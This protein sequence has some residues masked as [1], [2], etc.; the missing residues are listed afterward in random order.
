MRGVT[1]EPNRRSD[2]PLSFPEAIEKK[3]ASPSDKKD[4]KSEAINISGK[5]VEEIGFEKIQHQLA[6]LP[7]LRIVILDGLCVKGVEKTPWS[8]GTTRSRDEQRNWLQRLKIQELDLSRNLLESW[9][10]VIFINNSLPQLRALRLAGNRFRDLSIPLERSKPKEF[11]QLRELGLDD[12]LLDWEAIVSL[13]ADFPALNTLTASYNRIRTISRP[14]QNTEL[15]RLDL[16]FTE[17]SSI[18][19]IWPLSTLPN[20]KT[21]SLRSDPITTLKSGRVKLV[22]LR[23]LD[24]TSTLLPTLA[25]LSPIPVLF[26]TL[27]SLLTKDAPLSKHPSASLFTIAR[28]ANLTELNYSP[29][30]PAVRQNAELYYLSTIT[31]ELSDATSPAEEK[32][33]LA[34]H[35]RWAE[36]CR[37]YGEPEIARKKQQEDAFEAGTLGARVAKFIFSLSKPNLFPSDKFARPPSNE[38]ASVQTGLSI[39]KRDGD[40]EGEENVDLTNASSNAGESMA[41]RTRLLPLTISTYRLIGI[42][43]SLFSLR[44][45]SMQLILETDE[46]DPVTEEDGGWSVSEDDSSEDEVMDKRKSGETRREKGRWVRR[47]EELVGSTRSVGDWLPMGFGGKGAEVRVR[48]EI[49]KG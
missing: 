5:T 41:T 30:T 17:I 15:I 49:Q 29:I 18:D 32:Q 28:I 48:V 1:M 14:L 37:I 40:S 45:I 39:H 21:L 23:H 11:E 47:E 22:S 27:T 24:L 2:P 10:D 31:K 33:I 26:P 13:T 3:Y 8:A 34:F 42:A 19:D 43:A 44:P 35:A 46:S 4:S 36:L 6:A 7:E 20:L 25:S 12:T 16:S 9:A 38:K